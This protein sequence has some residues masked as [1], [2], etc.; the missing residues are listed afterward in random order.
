MIQQ[1]SCGENFF[2]F[3]YLIYCECILV[4]LYT[5]NSLLIELGYNEMTANIE[6]KIII[7]SLYCTDI[8][9]LISEKSGYFERKYRSLGLGI[10]RELTV[11]AIF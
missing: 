6:C 11:C 1:L 2:L 7:P 9:G 10:K 3:H 8:V 5:V 4:F